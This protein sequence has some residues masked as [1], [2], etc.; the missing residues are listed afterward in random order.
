MH[1]LLA[2]EVGNATMEKI[3]IKGNLEVHFGNREYTS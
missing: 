1:L 2:S 3:L